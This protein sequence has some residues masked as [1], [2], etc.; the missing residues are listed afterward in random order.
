MTR[1]EAIRVLK[2]SINNDIERT[3]RE[4]EEFDKLLFEAVDMAIKALEER[5]T[6]TWVDST[7]ETW[8]PSRRC[9]NCGFTRMAIANVSEAIWNFCP[10]CGAD[11]RGENDEMDVI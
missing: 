4:W 8:T 7:E 2:D 3:P 11:M 9:D 6:G 5:P 10:N 1:D